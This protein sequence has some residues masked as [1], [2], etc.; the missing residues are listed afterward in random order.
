MR[1]KICNEEINLSVFGAPDDICYGCI[2]DSTK[3]E[4]VDKAISATQEEFDT[5]FQDYIICPY[6][7][8][9]YHDSWEYWTAE[10][11][12]G[13]TIEIDCDKCKMTFIVTLNMEVTYS[14]EKKKEVERG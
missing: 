6:C 14:T 8:E 9:E 3:K 7:G 5:S 4:V 13:D 10:D 1:C 11:G 2:S 12:D